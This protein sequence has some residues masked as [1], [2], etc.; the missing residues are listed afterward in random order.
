MGLEKGQ[1][2]L[3]CLAREQPPERGEHDDSRIA[4]QQS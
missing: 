3:S 1:F 2:L 4:I